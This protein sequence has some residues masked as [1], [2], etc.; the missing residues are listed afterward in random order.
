M[1]DSRLEDARRKRRKSYGLFV[2]GYLLSGKKRH[3]VLSWVLRLFEGGEPS[4]EFVVKLLGEESGHS[5]ELRSPF[6]G[7]NL[8]FA[9]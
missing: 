8:F 1:K 7:L 4:I 2:I 9:A 6:Q 3:G 5:S